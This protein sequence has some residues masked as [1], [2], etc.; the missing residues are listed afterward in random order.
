MTEQERMTAFQSDMQ[1]AMERY[2][3]QLRIDLAGATTEIQMRMNDWMRTLGVKLNLSL[4]PDP[5]WVSPIVPD[6]P[7][8]PPVEKVLDMSEQLAA[9]RDKTWGADDP[10]ETARLKTGA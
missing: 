7:Q 8:M 3:I 1:A 5:V 2:G 9:W 4:V 6:T 10:H